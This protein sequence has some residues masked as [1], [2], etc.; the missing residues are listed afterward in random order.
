MEYLTVLLLAISMIVFVYISGQF[1]KDQHASWAKLYDAQ[2][3]LTTEYTYITL[4]TI[5]ELNKLLT[6]LETKYDPDKRNG[7][8]ITRVKSILETIDYRT[9]V[10]HNIATNID[11]K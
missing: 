2:Q 9:K 4:I 6:E 10:T 5:T 8:I 11:S 7:F 3:Q 1:A